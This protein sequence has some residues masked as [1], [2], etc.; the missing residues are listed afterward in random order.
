MEQVF[1]Q[2]GEGFERDG[3][4]PASDKG[5]LRERMRSE[6][7]APTRDALAVRPAWRRIQGFGQGQVHRAVLVRAHACRLVRCWQGCRLRAPRC[8]CSVKPW[9]ACA[10][11]C[12]VTRRAVSQPLPPG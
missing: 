10:S 5:V 1:E 2:L 11:A 12:L 9:S 8:W 3:L 7:R 6:A 4:G